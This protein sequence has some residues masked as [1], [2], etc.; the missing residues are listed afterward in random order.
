MGTSFNL[1]RV[2]FYGRSLAEYEQMF[3]IKGSN[4]V[5]KSILDCPG[6][7]ASF[8]KEARQMGIHVCA[9]DPQFKHDPDTLQSLGSQ[10]IDYVISKIA[11]TSEQRKWDYYASLE[12][13]R[14]KQFEIFRTFIADYR[15]DWPS[16][17]HYLAASLPHL[18]FEDQAFD[19]ALSGHFL[20]SFH[21]HFS[22]DLTIASLLELTR[23]AREVR[24]FPL[25]SNEQDREVLFADFDRIT[26]SLQEHEVAF[27]VKQ[28]NFEFQKG[29]NELMILRRDQTTAV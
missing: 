11:E 25:R 15:Q 29:A 10:D 26:E 22:T 7:P 18:P 12:S 24:V 5:N 9:V 2:T 3:L 21:T 1:E 4:W 6:G 28:A 8:G 17:T 14:N 19:L 20:F 23:V 13:L 27:E 16:Q